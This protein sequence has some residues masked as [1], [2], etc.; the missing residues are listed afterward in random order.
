VVPSFRCTFLPDMLA[1]YDHGESGHRIVQ[2][3]DADMV[4]AAS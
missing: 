1:L 4:F 3:H 2:L